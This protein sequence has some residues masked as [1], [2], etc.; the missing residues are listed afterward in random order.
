MSDDSDRDSISAVSS[1]AILATSICAN[2][3]I[4]ACIILAIYLVS[5]RDNL[6]IK[7][8][9]WRLMLITL[10]GVSILAVGIQLY[11]YSSEEEEWK[12]TA[13]PFILGQG[14]I[15]T[16]SPLLVRS[17]RIRRIF[18]SIQRYR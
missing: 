12:C 5:H 3:V 14:F 17:I 11:H 13:I 7:R 1:N 2:L 8:M 18:S 10:T 9:S 16:F 4:I 6:L 15:M